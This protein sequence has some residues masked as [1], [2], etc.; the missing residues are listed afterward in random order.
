ME[1]RAMK[2]ADLDGTRDID[3]TIESSDYLHIHHEGDGFQGIWKMESRPLREKRLHRNALSDEQAFSNKQIVTGIEDGIALV[4]EHDGLI[5][6]ATTV[7]MDAADNS[8]RLADLRV[9]FDFRRQG[10]ASAM[11]FQIV[12]EARRRQLR[13]VIAQAVSD[14]FPALEFLAKLNFE[15]T[16]FDTHAKSNHDLVKD[17]VVLF[18]YLALN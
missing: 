14:N 9:D 3:A 18:W 15:L 1:I 11:A 5:V 7:A 10:L 17:S 8:F 6:A 12:H 2:A 16:G 4:A 13:A